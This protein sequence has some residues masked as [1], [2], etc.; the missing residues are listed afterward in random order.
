MRAA[1]SL[2]HQ[3]NLHRGRRGHHTWWRKCPWT[4]NMGISYDRLKYWVHL[5]LHVN[6]GP[7]E[8]VL[9]LS[10]SSICPTYIQCMTKVCPCPWF[11]LRHLGLSTICLIYPT[12]VLTKS[13]TSMDFSPIYV[14]HLSS[15]LPRHLQKIGGQFLDKYWNNLFSHLPPS[16]PDCGQKEDKLWIGQIQV[17]LRTSGLKSIDGDKTWIWW[18]H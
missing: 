9:L 1:R 18:G 12:N 13:R 4:L 14:L 17:K 2:A 5:V 7:P 3:H 15:A 11:V 16:H 6:V 10:M 8:F